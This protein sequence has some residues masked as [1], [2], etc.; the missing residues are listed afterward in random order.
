MFP[1]QALLDELAAEGIRIGVSEHLALGKLLRRY[2]GCSRS[3]FRSA[4][5]ALLGSSVDE[6]G[7]IEQAFDRLYPEREPP[8]PEPPRPEPLPPPPS[9]R[10]RRAISIAIAVAAVAA[11]AVVVIFVVPPAGSSDKSGTTGAGASGGS[12]QGSG[13]GSGRG[14]GSGSGQGSG[15]GSS[16]GSS[17]GAPPLEVCD[18][19][20]AREYEETETS[21]VVSGAGAAVAL[22]ILL[23]SGRARGRRRLRAWRDEASRA[24]SASVAGPRSYRIVVKG[25]IQRDERHAYGSL[26]TALQHVA[27]ERVRT[28][29]LDVRRTLRDTLRAFPRIVLALRTRRVPRPVV[30]LEDTALDM[31]PWRGKIESL[32]GGLRREGVPIVHLYFSHAVARVSPARHGARAPLASYERAHP[33]SPLVII[34][35]GA[36]LPADVVESWPVRCWLNPVGDPDLW[37]EPVRDQVVWPITKAGLL[38][39]SRALVARRWARPARDDAAEVSPRDARLFAAL[40]ALAPA[41]SFEL[42]ELVRARLFPHAPEELILAAQPWMEPSTH[43]PEDREALRE[44]DPEGVHQRRLHEL[45]V[46]V[47]EASEPPRGSAAH[48]R[49]RRDRALQLVALRDAEGARE[50]R[51][52]ASDPLADELLVHLEGA[53][54]V[55]PEPLRREVAVTASRLDG[56]RPRRFAWPAPAAFLACAV[57]LAATA[58]ASRRETSREMRRVTAYELGFHPDPPGDEA[59]TIVPLLPLVPTPSLYQDGVPIEDSKYPTVKL[60]A[61]WV[62]R[63]LVPACYQLEAIQDNVQYVS[64]PVRVLPTW[65][66]DPGLVVAK[67]IPDRGRPGDR[68]TIAGAGFT[69]VRRTVQV[70]FGDVTAREARVLGDTELEVTVPAVAS[71]RTRMTFDFDPGGSVV[72]SE[73]TV[74]DAGL[75]P[76]GSTAIDAG[77]RLEGSTAID[78]D[79]TISGRKITIAPGARFRVRHGATLRIVA[80]T[81]TIEGP[82][83]IDGTG[84][85]GPAGADDDTSRKEIEMLNR[86][87][88][89]RTLRSCATIAPRGAPGRPGGPGAKIILSGTIV[90]RSN[91]RIIVDGGPGGPGGLGGIQKVLLFQPVVAP[92]AGQRGSSGMALV[93]QGQCFRIRG[94]AGARGPRGSVSEPT[95]P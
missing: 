48:L 66:S 18:D 67:A 38:R 60:L 86:V 21:A 12:G 42:A 61:T 52:L 27:S 13:R 94:P 95:S 25:A 23:I 44:L 65:G 43:A 36:M 88:Y 79:R 73:F 76:E 92:A 47:L 5:A 11:V 72:L 57:V 40:L 69:R 83:V 1:F 30:I 91:L 45:L 41:P 64:D 85:Q 31:A 33:G 81:I 35:C 51:A 22:L 58:Y 59:F 62:R 15:Q 63:T 70:Q 87:E 2:D 8:R 53:T 55:V 78:A 20:P 29:E 24:R 82:A 93:D 3:Q 37:P 54:A 80:E 10:R 89:E 46:S 16:Q 75:R 50:I 90:G 77:L 32:V 71:G 56:T 9:S 6:I 49:W 34:S 68:I 26:A 74:I 19:L 17:R 84:D 28:D 14:S 7:K 4:V 39:A